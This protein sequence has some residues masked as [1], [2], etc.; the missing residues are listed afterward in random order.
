MFL[1]IAEFS[2]LFSNLVSP[3]LKGTFI[4]DIGTQFHHVQWEGLHAWGLL[5]IPDFAIVLLI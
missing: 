5:K 4:F 2:H 1:L 3:Q